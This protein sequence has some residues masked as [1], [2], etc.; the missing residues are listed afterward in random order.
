MNSTVGWQY[1]LHSV[2]FNAPAETVMAALQMMCSAYVFN[3]LD[4]L[5]V[6]SQANVVIF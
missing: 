6:I 1:T 2:M 3:L 4:T 5:Y